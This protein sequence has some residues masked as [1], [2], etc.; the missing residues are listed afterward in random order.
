MKI[1]H[2]TTVDLSLRYLV[3]AQL[4][5]VEELGAEAIGISA[6]GPWVEEIEAAGITH[7]PLPSS[8]RGV[9][10]LADLAAAGQLLKILRRERPDILHTHN[11]KPGL[12]GRI[13]GR[14]AGVPI[15][16]NTVHGLYAAP[17]DPILKKTIVYVLEA[18]AARFSDLELV[19][20][21]EDL[22]LM[23]RLH[24]ARRGRVRLLGNGIDLTRYDPERADR[25]GRATVREELGIP[26]EQIVVG[27]VGRLVAEKGYLELFEAAG[28]L[29]DEYTILA[30]GPEDRDKPDALPGALVDDARAAGVRFLGMRTDLDDLYG[31]MDIF[32][33]PS[34]REGFPR[35]AMEA[36][37]M[38]LPVIAT[39]IR[40]CREVVD[41]EVNGLL[42]PVSSPDHLATAIVRLGENPAERERFGV[43]SRS[44][45]VEQFD[46]ERVVTRVL[47]AYRDVAE[48]KEI[49]DLRA[50][51]VASPRPPEIRR[52]TTADATSLARL[53]REGISGGFLPRLG[54]GFMRRLYEAMVQ[55]DEAV[56][57]VADRG[58][59]PMGFVAGTTSTATFY[60]HF[61]RRHGLA[62]GA[63]ALPRLLRPSN[64]RRAWE[65]ARYG[66]EGDEW[67]DAE[68]LSMA[69]SP[70]YRGQ[71]IGH[72][73]GVALLGYLADLGSEQVKVVVGSANR[74]AI[75][76]YQKM[77][78][79]G[80][81]TT[82]VHPGETSQVLV[83]SR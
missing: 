3:F 82:E 12:Y 46:E 55:W 64:V 53:H 7:I 22:A 45:A 71:G 43:A 32:V 19:Q 1:A 68:L 21:R 59:G 34:H 31:A 70:A 73:L 78:F 5:S 30:I 14:W 77:G 66:G 2:L 75:G 80:A 24:L 26:P 25:K 83:W 47:D 38:G 13:L 36:A 40:G 17:D 74:P 72:D 18:L 29:G 44:K 65:T 63:T 23:K 60:R 62:A 4:L 41:H 50:Q 51:L 15:V 69:V 61:L 28:R 67:P 10:P 48:R 42:I 49:L 57:L 11:P 52:A 16:I 79:V 81:G 9:A 54:P 37:A 6:P 27:M 76:A 58:D 56:V 20:S 35:A 8:T 33:L 39:D